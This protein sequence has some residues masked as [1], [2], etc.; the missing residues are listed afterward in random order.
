MSAPDVAAD[1]AELDLATDRSTAGAPAGDVQPPA[2]IL[3]VDDHEEN[4]LAL[5]AV[6]EPL[7]QRLVCA[8]S[9]EEALRKLLH[10]EFAVILLDVRMPGMGGFETARYINARERTRHTPII[11]LTGHDV[12]TEYVFQ[13][14][15]A[16]AVDYV[17]KPF[18][19]AVMRSKVLVFVKLHQ[20]RMQ[21]IREV[22]ARAQAEAVATTVRKLQSLSDAALAH[23]Q[24]DELLSELLA[25]SAALFDA[26]TAGLLLT[27]EDKTRLML[28][29]T[30]GLEALEEGRTVSVDEGFLGAAFHA[31][32]AVALPDV[33]ADSALH[34]SLSR[35]GVG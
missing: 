27:N 16:G 14:Y 1:P 9:G 12:D 23:L 4:L 32:M 5:D 28:R 13:G 20:E 7:G 2:S 35:V 31:R 11:F 25:R 22:E 30:Y 19:P 6:L 15:E 26:E 24:L 33:A 34:P 8:R 17:L 18:E 10:D 29:A 21:R 3:L